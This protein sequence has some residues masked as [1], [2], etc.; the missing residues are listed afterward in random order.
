MIDPHVLSRCPKIPTQERGEKR[1]TDL[2]AAAEQLFASSGYEATTMNAIASLAGASIGSLYQF[3]PNKESVG[4]AL[5]REYMNELSGQIVALKAASP[6]A[7]Q[8]LGQKLIE[9]VFN[10]SVEHPACRVLGDVPSVQKTESF[11]VYS[12]SV[13][14]LLSAFA[15]SMNVAELSSIALASLLMVRAAVQGSRLVDAKTGATL[16]HEMQ[17]AI[18]AYLEERLKI[19]SPAPT[20]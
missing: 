8:V 4:N 11:G 20:R 18:G 17:R 2:L 10:Y 7:P 14:D 19:A 1:V 3:F 16:R 15:P 5:L 13:L 9:I 12:A 6:I